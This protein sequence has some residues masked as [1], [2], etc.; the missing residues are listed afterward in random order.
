M[1]MLCKCYSKCYNMTPSVNLLNV[2]FQTAQG[3]FC[4]VLVSFLIFRLRFRLGCRCGCRLR[5][6]FRFRFRVTL[7]VSR[8]TF[9]ITWN[10]EGV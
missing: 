6:R 8:A 9:H 4:R 2:F 1:L 3:L 7:V 10:L 5:F